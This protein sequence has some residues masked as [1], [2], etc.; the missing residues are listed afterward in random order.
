VA[1]AEHL[2]AHYR[3]RGEYTVGVSHRDIDRRPRG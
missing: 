1:I 3:E 2:A